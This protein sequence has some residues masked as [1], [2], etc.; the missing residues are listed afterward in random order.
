MTSSRLMG[1]MPRER[2]RRNASEQK[3]RKYKQIVSLLLGPDEDFQR[4]FIPAYFPCLFRALWAGRME[5]SRETKRSLPIRG[6][7]NP[8]TTEFTKESH[9]RLTLHAAF[10]PLDQSISYSDNFTV[11]P[12]APCQK[13]TIV[14]GSSP[15]GCLAW[16]S[17]S[18]RVRHHHAHGDAD[19]PRNL[20]QS[21]FLGLLCC[22]SLEQ[23]IAPRSS[24]E[25]YLAQ[26]LASR[27]MI[28]N[29]P[30]SDA[31]LFKATKSRS[32]HDKDSGNETVFVMGGA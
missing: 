20:R 9:A 18:S 17:A 6:S 22:A 29:Y 27:K 23:Q 26:T 21:R 30:L 10:L 3:R 1:A 28:T 19:P 32:P 12:A 24:T 4:P 2:F 8:S 5:K 25:D 7:T 13:R 16:A 31:S 15:K 14:K 11:C